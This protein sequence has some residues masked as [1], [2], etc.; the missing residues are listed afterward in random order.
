M[1]PDR[2]AILPISAVA[3]SWTPRSNIQDSYTGTP[4]Y[5]F[6]IFLLLDPEGL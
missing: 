4:H 3:Y 5:T 1:P 2:P 6:R